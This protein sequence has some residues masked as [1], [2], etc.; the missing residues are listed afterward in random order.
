MTGLSRAQ[1]GAWL[2][3]ER[4]HRGWSRPQL[5]RRLIDAAHIQ[6]DHSVPGLDSMNH[7]IYRWE[8]GSDRP[9]EYYQLLI[10]AVLGLPLPPAPANGT[11]HTITTLEPG[12][13][14]TSALTVTITIQLPPGTTADI[15]TQPQP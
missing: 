12:D 8:R 4:E 14:P 10:R 2:R 5:S 3:A 9:T 1:Y 15:T 13:G 11:A 6:G 7:N